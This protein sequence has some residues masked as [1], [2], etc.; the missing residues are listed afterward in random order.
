MQVSDQLCNYDI[1]ITVY[2]QILRDVNFK[3]ITNSAFLQFYFQGQPC[4]HLKLCGF[5]EHSLPSVL[6]T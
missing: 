3:D 5:H 1:C 2:V 4:R 6:H